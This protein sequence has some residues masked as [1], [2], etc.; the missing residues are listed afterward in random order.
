MKNGPL[1]APSLYLQDTLMKKV[2]NHIPRGIKLFHTSALRDLDHQR[3]KM[4]FSWS[5]MQE[6]LAELQENVIETKT[7]TDFHKEQTQA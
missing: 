1:G 2:Y 5:L 4:Y 6:K 7:F 3:L